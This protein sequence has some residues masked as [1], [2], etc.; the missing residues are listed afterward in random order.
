MARENTR[1]HAGPP[2]HQPPRIALPACLHDACSSTVPPRRKRLR[3]EKAARE[4]G[5]VQPKQPSR[6]R[7]GA[8]HVISRIRTGA[9]SSQLRLKSLTLS[10]TNNEPVLANVLSAADPAATQQP[11]PELPGVTLK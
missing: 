4:A 10:R 7:A 6:L 2:H 1:L 9:S 8:T 11:L 5:T 3:E